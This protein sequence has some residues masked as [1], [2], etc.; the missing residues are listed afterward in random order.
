MEIK[1][2]PLS[3]IYSIE[4]NVKEMKEQEKILLQYKNIFNL[5]KKRA[6]TSSRMM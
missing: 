4:I 2:E 6:K 5:F 1:L 3:L